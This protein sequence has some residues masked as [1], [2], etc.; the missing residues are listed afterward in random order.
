M[1]RRCSKVACVG[2]L[3]MAVAGCAVVVDEKTGETRVINPLKEKPRPG[4]RVVFYDPYF[5]PGIYI[6]RGGLPLTRQILGFYVGGELTGLVGDQRIDE[7]ISLSGLLTNRLEDSNTGFGGG[8]VVGYN[9]AIAYNVYAGVFASFD[10]I[11]QNIIRRFGGASFIGSS[12]NWML[13]AGLKVG[14]APSRNTS[15][16]GLVAASWLNEDLEINFGGPVTSEN[17]TLSGFT[18]GAGVEARPDAL[19][20]FGFPVSLYGQ[21]QHSWYQDTH[22][23]MPA[24]SPA[25]NYR[26]ERENDT[27]KF[28]VNLHIGSPEKRRP[29]DVGQVM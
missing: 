17:R 20:N 21:Y 8:M 10:G 1:W 15:V 22:L 14:Y 3:A 7:R 16:Y 26:Y 23:R 24:A 25:F 4:E 29:P 11:N 2:L 27:F 5:E 28:G 6:P 18:V 9:W 12:T 13:D 19:Q